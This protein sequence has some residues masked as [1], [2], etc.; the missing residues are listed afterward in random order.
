MAEE[1]KNKLQELE[2]REIQKK[3]EEKFNPK[4]K[5][6][7][8]VAVLYPESMIPNWKDE[9]D[10]ALQ[11]PYCY[12]VH[13]KDVL[14]DGITL[15]K[16]HVHLMIA[17]PSPTTCNHALTLFNRLTQ[18]GKG[19]KYC[20]LVANVRYMYNYLIHDTSKAKKD[21]KHIYEPCER[22]E[23]N[24]FDIG[25]Y[26]QISTVEKRQMKKEI[27]SLVDSMH[28]LNFMEMDTYVRE[29]LSDEH[30]DIF[31]TH[32]GYF[33]NLIRGHYN[34][35]KSKLTGEREV[36]SKFIELEKKKEKMSP[37]KYNDFLAELRM[38][39]YDIS[40]LTLKSKK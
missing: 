2:E 37:E 20:E 23:G 9:L 16:C 32:Q 18:K 17:F 34:S 4:S 28:F 27:A 29:H 38:D 31:T 3:G 25:S 13:D 39:Y 7:Y 15:R 14:K 11:L 10:D 40:A 30:Y 6:R 19:I 12:C 8:I 26:E 21:N 35:L 5:S 24:N 33:A 22:V 36:I 1:N